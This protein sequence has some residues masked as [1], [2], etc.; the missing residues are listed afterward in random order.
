LR[1]DNRMDKEYKHRLILVLEEQMYKVEDLSYSEDLSTEI[2]VHEIRKSFKRIN[3][4]LRLFPDT[5]KLEV[6][7]FKQPMRSMARRLTLARETTVNLQFFETMCTEKQCFVFQEAQDLKAQLAKEN[8][9]RLNELT[10]GESAFDTIYNQMQTGRHGF[11]EKLSETDF[12][13]DM[14]DELELSFQKSHDLFM[15]VASEYHPVE[16]HE[17]R[18][19]MKILWY[20]FE[21]VHPGQTEVPGT[22]SEKLHS[23]TDR[24]GDDHDWY[25][26]LQEIEDDKYAVSDSFKTSLEE[27]IGQYQTT[28]LESLNQSLAEFFREENNEFRKAIS[29]I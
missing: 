21:F 23:I 7:S 19:Q 18:K 22:L 28:N 15:A 27:I 11:L 17:L 6:Q 12:E 4:L 25:I 13:I 29:S 9:D 14:A 24:L 10:Q 8:V 26:F 16:F 5:L 2:K 20:Q 1:N 3:A